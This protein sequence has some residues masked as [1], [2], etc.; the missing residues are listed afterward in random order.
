MNTIG[1]R[2]GIAA[3][4]AVL[5]ITPASAQR[6]GQDFRYDQKRIPFEPGFRL[7]LVPD[8]EG[9]GSVVTNRETIA[10]VEGPRY[11]TGS[12]RDYDQYR[13][14]LTKEVNAVIA[15][16]RSAGARSFVINEGHGGNMF[17]N[18]LPWEMDQDAILIRGFPRPNVMSTAIDSTFGTMMFTG[19]H[20]G[21]GMGGVMSHMYAFSRFTVNGKVL[22]EVGFN[23]L[24]A[25]E[26]GVSVSLVS[27]DDVLVKESQE[28]LGNGAIGVVTKIAVGGNAA[29]TFSPGKV[30]QMLKDSA[31]LAVRREM[32]GDFKP[33][34]MSRPYAVELT[35]RTFSD[36]TMR[37]I[38]ELLDRFNVK[39]LDGRSYAMTANRARDIGYF[40]DAV[41]V[42][43][44]RQPV[45][46]PTTR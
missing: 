7:Y 23:A 24:V 26:M 10:G 5:L 3:L 14:L 17:A 37:Q 45:T 4:F 29:I 38:D 40:L 30:Q 9:M 22:N 21:P 41:E 35:F 16:A 19:A 32:R 33:F 6:G 15:G 43:V 39:K 2:T 1:K 20:A 44:L 28:I 31:A 11:A 36:D 18:V 46:P 12:G 25:G 13:L 42:I 8:M 27:G 34:V